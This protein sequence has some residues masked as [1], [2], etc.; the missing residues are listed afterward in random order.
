MARGF[1][2]R[3]CNSS[4]AMIHSLFWVKMLFLARGR[5]AIREPGI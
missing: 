1:L 5:A 3:F 2:N 4:S